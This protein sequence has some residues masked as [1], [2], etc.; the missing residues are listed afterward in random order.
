[1]KA[2]RLRRK[3]ILDIREGGIETEREKVYASLSAFSSLLILQSWVLT[4]TGNNTQTKVMDGMG[5]GV[6]DSRHNRSWHQR[7]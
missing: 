6:V 2:P 1:M 4:I 7:D 5:L 3:S